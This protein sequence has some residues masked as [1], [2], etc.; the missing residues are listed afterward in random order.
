MTARRMGIGLLGAA[1]AGPL[2]TPAMTLPAWAQAAALNVPAGP[3]EAVLLAVGRQ[4]GLHFAYDSRLTAGLRSAGVKGTLSPGQAV[5]QALAGTGLLY[6]FAGPT[7]VRIWAPGAKA[8]PAA[9]DGG[10]VLDQVTLHAGSD[11]TEG[12]GVYSFDAPTA[13]ATGLALTPR[14]TPQAI[15]VI[16][17]QQIRDSGAQSL[18]D[19]LNQTPGISTSS[20]YGD[21]RWGYFARGSSISNLQYDGISQPGAWWAQEGSPDDMVVYDHIEVVRGATGLK[22]GPGNPS[23]SVNMVRKRPL[24]DAQTTLD[25]N[26]YDYGTASIKLDASR[27]LNAAGTVHGRLLAFGRTGDTWRA[28]QSRKTGLIYGALDIDID[29]DTTLGLGLSYQADRIDGYSW[30]GFWLRPDGGS[31]DF[32][33]RDNPAA[34][35]EYLSRRQTVAYADLTH[36]LSPDWTL[37]LAGRLTSGKRD[38]FAGYN[39]WQDPQTLM[40]GGYLAPG[41]ENSASVSVTANGTVQTF[42]REHQ[43]AFGADWARVRTGMKA[44]TFYSMLTADPSRPDTW[45]HPEPVRDGVVSWQ[46]DDSTRQ[47]GLF[48]SGRFEI[49][50]NLHA[51]AGGRLA[52][53]EINDLSGNPQEGPRQSHGFNTKARTVPYLGLI[54]DLNDQWTVYAS[55]T[56]IFL[57]QDYTDVSGGKLPPATG[58]N[59]EL[60]IKGS[61]L[62]GGLDLSAALFDTRMDGLPE[63]VTPASLCSIPQDGGCYRAAETVTTRGLD[64]EVSGS[65]A[66]GWNLLAGY[67]FADSAYSAGANDGKRYNAD[68]VP[69]HLAKLTVSRAFAG[70]LQGLTLGGTL[71]AQSG[72]Y[73][74]GAAANGRAVR[75]RQGGYAVL[76]VMA[77]Y[78]LDQGTALQVNIDNLLDRT[79]L[80]GLGVDWPN[81]FYSQPRT[82]SLALTKSF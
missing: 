28:A 74:E 78:E 2:L 8:T 14:E 68:T 31:Y 27:P 23:A 13:T 48:A 65:P 42:G 58:S 56:E 12:S 70:A 79:Y 81:S 1:L 32:G 71:R 26:A 16:T 72:I 21:A 53:H 75:Q 46:T 4:A 18:T 73:A 62:D 17:D 43:L 7:E 37:R 60:G 9:A 47:W 59:R 35:W 33:P 10:V 38:R 3:L 20:Q 69:R 50:P 63:Q 82:V 5:A 49:A 34:A 25:I 54:Y 40:R 61:L 51:I 15:S 39:T 41:Y 64:L 29:A 67:T 44:N 55:Y 57:P 77:R 45:A 52:W 11:R 24:P 66:P 19:T 76:D 36:E 6:S 80:T 30:G 22:E